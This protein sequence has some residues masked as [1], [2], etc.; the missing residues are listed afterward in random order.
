MRARVI[1]GHRG[2][3][4]GGLVLAALGAAVAGCTRGPASSSTAASTGSATATATATVSGGS[5]AAHPTGTARLVVFNQVD[6]ADPVRIAIDGDS[7]YDATARTS[8]VY[9]K[10]VHR[11]ELALAR[12]K[13]RVDVKD[14]RG[15]RATMGFTLGDVANVIVY[16]NKD[17]IDVEVNAEQNPVYY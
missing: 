1:E 9:P 13:H 10:I 7:V 3:A 17:G 16:L 8:D 2:R 6:E 14:N 15:F 12:G 4:W 11:A 5:P